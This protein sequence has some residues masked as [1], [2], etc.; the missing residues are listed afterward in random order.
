[1]KKTLIITIALS[2]LL[3]TG[4]GSAPVELPATTDSTFSL[5]QTYVI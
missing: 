1:M 3:L 2:A 4:C 5:G